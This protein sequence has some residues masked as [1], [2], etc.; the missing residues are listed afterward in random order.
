MRLLE[1]KYGDENLDFAPV[2]FGDINLVVG[3]SG[4]GKTKFL[5]ALFAIAAKAAINNPQGSVLG[6]WRLL[7]EHKKRTFR[8]EYES[9]R[10]PS[11]GAEITKDIVT[12]IKA[13]EAESILINRTS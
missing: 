12:E 3:A 5:S 11:G 10:L 9:K 6:D 7:F 1:F 2:T 4:A 13:G 8:W